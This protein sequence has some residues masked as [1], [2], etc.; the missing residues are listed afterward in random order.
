MTLENAKK[1]LI[2]RYKYLYENAYFILSP[3]M[4]EETMEEF[5]ESQKEFNR[6]YPLIYLN[7]NKLDNINSLFEEFLLFGKPMEESTLYK[8]IESKRKDKDYLEKV[9]NGL[10]L[11]EKQKNTNFYNENLDIWQILDYTYN[12]IQEQSGDLKHKKNKLYVLDEYYRIL[13]Y[14]NDGKIYKSGR[15]LILD[16]CNSM[17]IPINKKKPIRVKKDIG[18]TRN[19]FVSTIANAHNYEYNWSIFT[20]AEKQEIY[21]TYHDEL[22]YDLQIKCDI[23]E[24]Y[25]EALLYRPDNTNP[26]EQ[27]FTV[28][29]EE[30][31]VDFKNQLYKYYQLCPHCGYIVN[32]PIDILSEGIKQRIEERCNKDDK[33]FRKMFLYSELFSLDNLATNEQKKLLKK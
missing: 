10:A 26:C 25:P 12:Y 8:T 15:N 9:K 21:L 24:E 1:E 29:E 30:I 16:E 4:C 27:N 13:R 6:K 19:S 11:L 32:I 22:P 7:I 20:E 17:I 23:N 33:L 28:K 5:E 31:F 3:F 18:V 14:R 2:K